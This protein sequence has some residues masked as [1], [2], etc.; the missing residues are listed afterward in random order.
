MSGINESLTELQD[1]L[2]TIDLQIALRAHPRGAIRL[3]VKRHENIS[4]RM[5]ASKNYGRPHIHVDYGQYKNAASY[6]ID[7]GQRLVGNLK[8][9][10]DNA[11]RSCIVSNNTLLIELC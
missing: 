2:A 8:T 9:V 3:P 4:L 6:A 1:I 5:A 10:Y 7:D 11:I